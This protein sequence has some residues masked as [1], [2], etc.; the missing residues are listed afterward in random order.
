[1]AMVN[2]QLFTP[3]LAYVVD[4]QHAA[5]RTSG[6]TASPPTR[7]A[8]PPRVKKYGKRRLRGSVHRRSAVG[9]RRGLTSSAP[10]NFLLRNAFEDVEIE[11]LN[12]E[13]DASEQ[14]RSATLERV[15]VDGTAREG[16]RDGRPEGAA[17]HLSR[18]GDHQDGAGPDSAERS[19]QRV[20]DGG[21]RR[22]GCRSGRRASCRC[23]RCRRAACRR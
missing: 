18:R 5:R 9:R 19:R 22:R 1:M 6:R 10:I 12:L 14:P 15:W 13:I 21:R 23:S 17:A 4:P 16:R 7:S 20:D 2:D 11:G 3:L 8:A